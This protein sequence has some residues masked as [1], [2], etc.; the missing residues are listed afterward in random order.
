MT[1]QPEITRYDEQKR[2]QNAALCDFSRRWELDGDLMRCRKCKRA[3]IFSKR[4]Q[5]MHHAHECPQADQTKPWDEL[6]ALTTANE[7]IA[8]L[9]K[10]LGEQESSFLLR[11]E[12]DQRAIKH[13]QEATGKELTWPD[14]ADLCV[15]L[16]E[17]NE[18][19]RASLRAKAEEWEKEYQNWHMPGAH[20]DE[21][22]EDDDGNVYAATIKA[23]AAELRAMEGELLIQG[24]VDM[25]V[26]PT[27]ENHQ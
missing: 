4:D 1:T 19:I 14:H 23:C 27:K 3:I 6:N 22:G 2:D 17:Q 16:L 8:E 7:R 15:W 13:W 25:N 5:D 20:D 21:T 18:A 26:W 9:A 24:H 10:E 12:A 11:W